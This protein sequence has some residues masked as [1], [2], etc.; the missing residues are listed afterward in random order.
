MTAM[1]P[2]IEIPTFD[3]S[4][5]SW[6]SF[7][8]AFEALVDKAPSLS[9]V[10][11]LT[12]LM[13]SLT[14]S[15]KQAV[16]G[17]QTTNA[18][19]QVVKGI[20][21]DRYG[22]QRSLLRELTAQLTNLPR[23]GESLQ[24]MR[25]TFEDLER[26]L[27]ILESLGQD[28]DQVLMHQSVES[29]LPDSLLDDLGHMK[30][31]H[32]DT[33]NMKKLRQV[34]TEKLRIKEEIAEINRTRGG[35]GQGQHYQDP[36]N[37]NQRNNSNNRRYDNNGP[38]GNSYQNGPRPSAAFFT[39]NQKRTPYCA[40]CE[41]QTHY[42]SDCKK[43]ASS[44]DRK[45]Q[46]STLELCYKCLGKGH[47]VKNCRSVK[48]CLNCKKG[49][50]TAL[51]NVPKTGSWGKG[52]TYQ[53]S[54]Q[55]PQGQCYQNSNQGQPNQ[56]SAQ[57]PKNNNPNH[58]GKKQNTN[59]G[60]KVEVEG[61]V[62]NQRPIEQPIYGT[63]TAPEWSVAFP[64]IEYPQAHPPSDPVTALQVMPSPQAM[65]PITN[66][67][68]EVMLHTCFAEV[69]DEKEE[70]GAEA[71]VFLDNGAQTS[72]I[73]LTLA[74]KLGLHPIGRSWCR[75]GTITSLNPKPELLPV[76]AVKIKSPTG[77][78][79]K[80]Y[81]KGVPEMPPIKALKI[82]NP[83]GQI[84]RNPQ[85]PVT[86]ETSWRQP[87]ILIGSDL[88]HCFRV[89][90]I[91]SLSTGATVCSSKIGYG[92]F[93][94]LQLHGSFNPKVLASVLSERCDIDVCSPADVEKIRSMN[95]NALDVLLRVDL[96]RLFRWDIL[97]ITPDPWENDDDRAL[98]KFEEGI[99]FNNEEKRYMS[100]IPWI[101][102]FPQLPKNKLV[103]RRWLESTFKQLAKN[104]DDLVRY[105][106]SIKTQID[107][108]VQEVVTDTSD[109]ENNPMVAYTPHL[110][111]Y[112]EGKDVRVVYHASVSVKGKPSI[113]QLQYRGRL[114]L[115]QGAGMIL[116]FRMFLILLICDIRKAFHQILLDPIDRP[117]T[118]SY[119][120][121]D[122]EKGLDDSNIIVLQFRS[123]PFGYVSSPFILSAT[124]RVHL[125][126][127]NTDIAREILQN[128][129][130]DNILLMSRTPEEAVLKAKETEAIFAK[131]SMGIHEYVSNNKEVN[132]KFA[133]IF[134]EPLAK[135]ITKFLGIPWDTERD[136][137]IF[138]CPVTDKD[139]E[140]KGKMTK[141]KVIHKTTSI[142]DPTGIFSPALFLLKI[143][144]QF[145]WGKQLKWDSFLGQDDE[146]KWPG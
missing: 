2:K 92:L 117:S 58:K 66:T 6:F 22:N 91:R 31:I 21:K 52:Q 15:A 94:P 29:K 82:L 28:M 73:N 86:F 121:K 3:G 71:V 20:L 55:G 79:L 19:Y 103:A 70:K 26:I 44:E 78:H 122:I 106:K 48:A 93:G 65:F 7:Y 14:G 127:E 37:R 130:V 133:E 81:L 35:Q 144:Y 68:H 18:N 108:R 142:Y 124:I 13:N 118:R 23:A 116:R 17:I 34:I 63:N 139:K 67:Q 128:I 33:W 141:R 39:T 96:E 120:L 135:P 74:R 75:L 38:R 84:E 143:F 49:H 25:K 115:P 41:T 134:D 8:D 59:R 88:Y 140:K 80:C 1:L 132:Q 83:L 51:C 126:N 64:I 109:E 5:T 119:W 111:V 89:K 27:R 72:I 123:V 100:R 11:K 50:H 104:W 46:A 9:D 77:E 85:T 12:I 54:N 87:D 138:P 137:L 43:Y 4:L 16:A 114:F 69:R 113:N 112:K 62:L 61:A 136:L 53:N 110:P 40:F 146:E 131:A 42:S 102:E 101:D 10:Q 45:K 107:N 97:A 30:L 57:K 47:G 56:G 129:Y 36:R 95:R 125:A 145:L 98:K 99:K 32:G 76:F 24:S 90:H 60:S 105:D